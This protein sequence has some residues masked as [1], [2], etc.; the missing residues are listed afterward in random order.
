M[1]YSGPAEVFD[2]AKPVLMAFGDRTMFVGDEIGHASA[3]DV[4]VPP[5][6]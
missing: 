2:R 3:F 5:S 4:A 6:A 1:F